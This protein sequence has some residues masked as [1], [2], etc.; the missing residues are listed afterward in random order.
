MREFFKGF[1]KGSKEFNYA[2]TIIINS[3][4]LSVVYV[5]GVGL[6]SLFAKL[7]GKNFL[8]KTISKQSKTYWSDLNLKKKTLE[9][10]YRQF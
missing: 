1:R 3:I 10:Y 4:L 7:F 9:E 6:T 5:L 8:E 2:L